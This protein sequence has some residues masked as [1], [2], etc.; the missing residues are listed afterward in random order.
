[1]EVDFPQ[2]PATDWSSFRLRFFVSLRADDVPAGK[3]WIRDVEM[4]DQTRAEGCEETK[5]EPSE[6]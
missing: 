2:V 5:T 6:T 1:M 3:D 4:W